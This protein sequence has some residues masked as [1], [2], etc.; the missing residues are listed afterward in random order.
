LP[1]VM[2]K[3]TRNSYFFCSPNLLIYYL[4]N[5]PKGLYFDN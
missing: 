1:A 3:V 4:K 2:K 5:T